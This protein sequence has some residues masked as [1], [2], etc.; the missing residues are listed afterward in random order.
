MTVLRVSEDTCRGGDVLSFLSST[1]HFPYPCLSG[2]KSLPNP[3]SL[4]PPESRR[5]YTS[6]FTWCYKARA[7]STNGVRFNLTVRLETYFVII[8]ISSITCTVRYTVHD[9]YQFLYVWAPR[10]YPQGVITK[11]CSPTCQSWFCWSI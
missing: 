3:G 9:I 11:V 8:N 1:I 7:Y 5:P 2:N 10:C 6:R 4:L